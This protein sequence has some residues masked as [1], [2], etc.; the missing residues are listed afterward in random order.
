MPSCRRPAFFEHSARAQVA[1]DYGRLN[2]VDRGGIKQMVDQQASRLRRNPSAPHSR[3][4]LIPDLCLEETE[5]EWV[6]ETDHTYRFAVVAT[7]DEVFRVVWRWHSL[8]E[9][10]FA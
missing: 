4:H 5:R 6:V 7:R 9:L 3:V 2:A 8:R 10:L 1:H